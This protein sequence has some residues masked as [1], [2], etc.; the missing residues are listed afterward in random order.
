MI[1]FV[2]S[3]ILLCFS[4]VTEA[5]RKFTSVDLCVSNDTSSIEVK[6]CGHTGREMFFAF[7]AN[8]TIKK[9]LV[10]LAYAII[11]ISV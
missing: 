4:F 2:I 9:L 1:K 11:N 7:H 6:K 8:K 5:D 10:N 3:F